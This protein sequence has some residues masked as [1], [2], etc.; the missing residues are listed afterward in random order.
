MTS[1]AAE[2][3][4]PEIPPDKAPA[5][6]ALPPPMTE[7]EVRQWAFAKR[8]CETADVGEAYRDVFQPGEA[9]QPWFHQRGAAMLK[10]ED[11]RKIIAHIAGPALV[12]LGVDKT[13]V[14]RR[15]LETIDSDITDYIG[16]D[17]LLMNGDDM[18]DLPHAKRRLVKKLKE[19]YS[20]LTG[21]LV[22]REIELEPKHPAMQLLAGIQQWI[23]PGGDTIVN[24]ETIVTFMTVANRQAQVR[25]KELRDKASTS[26]SSTQITR[27]AIEG[28]VIK[29]EVAPV[30]NE[31]KKPVDKMAAFR[32]KPLDEK[33]GIVENE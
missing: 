23:K 11:V 2:L 7:T 16:A 10:H 5:M 17:G 28:T 13:H 18:R 1:A 24:N 3:E 32:D 26:N 33:S 20:P 31:L 15:L 27:P 12:E 29:R 6:L 22:S 19:R 21:E 30:P 25:A 8:V 4:V 9:M 14:I